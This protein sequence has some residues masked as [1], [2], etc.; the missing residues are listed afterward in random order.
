MTPQARHILTIMN[1][2]IPHVEW[3]LVN[4]IDRYDK[5]EALKQLGSLLDAYA[6]QSRIL[7]DM[8][9]VYK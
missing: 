1:A 4:A 3:S 7:A 8:V 6:L 9:N 5:R 2:T